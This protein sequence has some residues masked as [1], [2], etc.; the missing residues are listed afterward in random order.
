MS[1]LDKSVGKATESMKKAFKSVA[2]A[3]AALGIGKYVKDSIQAASDLEGAFLGLQSIVEGQGR[4]FSKAKEFI[5]SYV[6]DGLVPLTDA[7]TAYKNLAARGYNDEQ[8]QQVMGRLKDAA[9]F[10]RQSS[11]TLGAAVATATEGLKNENSILV[12]NAGVTKNVAKMWDEYAASIGKTA[13]N[14]TQQEKIH[15]EVN[16]I[17]QETQ[18]QV[19]DAAKYANTFAGRLA[20]LNKTFQDVRVNVGQAFTPIANYVIP[21]LQ[22]LGNWLVRVTTY[23]KYFMQAFF[24]V[25]TAQKQV[26]SAVGGGA[27]A[28]EKYGTAAQKAGSKV[29]KAA[30][31]AKR[32]VAGF[33]EI[34][35]LA[36]KA[37]A[38][39]GDTGSSALDPSAGGIGSDIG[40][41]DIT[42]PKVDTETIPKNIKAMA[43]RIKR[44]MLSIRDAVKGIGTFFANE[45]K[46][47]GPALQP[48]RDAVGPIKQSMQE[49]GETFLLFVGQYLKPLIGYLL[50]DFIPNIVTGFVRDFAPVFANV[51]VGS[52]EL[53][54]KTFK[55]V[56]DMM[57][58]LW[59][60][61][62]LPSLDLIKN[63]IMNAN[64]SAANSWNKLWDGTL[65]PLVDYFLNGFILPIAKKMNEVLVPIF[66]DILVLGFE[67]TAS[68]F[69]WLAN[70]MSDIY[71]TVIEP[72]FN[73]IKK[74]V[75]DTLD[76]VMKLWEKHGKNLMNNLTDLFEGIQNTF[77]L[78]WDNI[79]KP[80]VE[81]FLEALTFLWDKHLKGLIEQ[82]GEFIMKLVNGALEIYN[83]FIKPIIDALII[84][85]GPTFKVAF[86]LIVD[87]VS[88]AIAFLSDLMKGLIQILGGLIDF[89]VGVFT[90][91]WS[92]AWEG[93]KSIFKGVF[94][95]LWGI[96]KFP[97]NLIID[98]INSVIG[99]LNSI[100]IDIPDWFPGD[101]GGK[102]FGI[103]IPR[104]PKLARG[105]IVDGATNFGNYIAGE[106]GPEMV[107]PLENTSFVDKLASALGTAVMSAMQ[108]S[109]TSND[110]GDI[111]IQLDGKTLARVL[112]PYLGK[113]KNRIGKSIITT[114]N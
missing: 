93:V 101:F 16:G 26:T 34:N 25:S 11:Y 110:S 41:G 96:V 57:V 44:S 42:M 113:E 105:G 100:H 24:G 33:D 90:G 76:I 94:D 59:N 32:S 6:A 37:S 67:R 35:A 70:L 104:I 91:N 2:V 27:V 72:V 58:S 84:T 55:N 28:Q 87:V 5:N 62:W 65:K 40:I 107:V 68:A 17:M 109:K 71:K 83:K 81:P 21:I 52:F 29:K 49:M 3:I 75:M 36:D 47:I 114:T 19:G 78:L 53:L 7:V 86:T 10:G 74:I 98:G 9:A 95:S 31:E 64:T 77:Q 39:S 61:T 56:T 23:F 88:T 1:G 66:T 89:I 30:A 112:N 50:T 92:K 15:A 54:S 63:A 8:I 106:A 82:V 85:L 69:D 22:K 12:D 48:L 14:L 20:M 51:A 108:F 43:D 80:I 102:S 18:F 99:A 13:N 79:L 97:L 103:N 4:S 38:A 73:F 111:V 60:S 46:G 45:F